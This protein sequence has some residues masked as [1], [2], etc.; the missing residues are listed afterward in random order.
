[1]DLFTMVE[2]AIYN[3]R[4]REI[5]RKTDRRYRRL[6][7]I[8]RELNLTSIE[9]KYDYLMENHPQFV[10][11]VDKYLNECGRLTL[12]YGD[13]RDLDYTKTHLCNSILLG[14]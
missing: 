8:D 12:K 6:Q 4:L 1:M 11:M 9:N 13:S 2:K 10:R 14:D 3:S 5:R 7:M